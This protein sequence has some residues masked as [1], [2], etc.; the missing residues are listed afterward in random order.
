MLQILKCFANKHV[1]LSQYDVFVCQNTSIFAALCFTRC[2]N[3]E[4]LNSHL[5]SKIS[6]LFRHLLERNSP[7][8]RRK[9]V[10]I[11]RGDLCVWMAVHVDEQYPAVGM[12]SRLTQCLV[13]KQVGKT[14][15][16]IADS[17]TQRHVGRQIHTTTTSQ[18]TQINR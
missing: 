2:K 13:S 8:E 3:I 6:I 15:S 9:L 18:T 14:Y 16:I 7:H 10:R 4:V 12:L 5:E 11:I 17:T 1:I